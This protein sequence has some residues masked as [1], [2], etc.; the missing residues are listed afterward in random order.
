MLP[1]SGEKL[2]TNENLVT[3]RLELYSFVFTANVS[4]SKSIW[5]R[6]LGQISSV[7]IQ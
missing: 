7:C 2:H 4:C 3:K 5:D 1:L 6:H